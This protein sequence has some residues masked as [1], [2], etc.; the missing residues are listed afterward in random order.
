[1]AEVVGLHGGSIRLTAL[2]TIVVTHLVPLMSQ[3]RTEH[4][5]VR[6]QM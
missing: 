3:F 5:A 4:G 2:P 1:M 6:V